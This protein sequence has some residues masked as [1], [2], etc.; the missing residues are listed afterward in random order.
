MCPCGGFTGPSGSGSGVLRGHV[1]STTV[2]GGGGS[3]LSRGHGTVDPGVPTLSLCLSGLVTVTLGRRR[4]WLRIRGGACWRVV[5][6]AVSG[7][8]LAGSYGVDRP[9]LRMGFFGRN[10]CLFVRHRRGAAF[11][12]HLSF[13]KGVVGTLHLLPC[14][15]GETLGTNLVRQQHDFPS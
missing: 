3:S 1:P 9:G 6:L 5:S 7:F 4:W 12:W 2:F 11:G 8:G 10:P 15:P 14:V 13:L